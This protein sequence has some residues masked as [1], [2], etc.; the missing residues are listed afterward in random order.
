MPKKPPPLVVQVDT[1]PEARARHLEAIKYLLRRIEE[2]RARNV[3]ASKLR[4][5][6]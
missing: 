4:K 3:E 1:S 5:S 6:A 2:K